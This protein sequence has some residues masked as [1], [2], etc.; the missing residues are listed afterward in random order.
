MLPLA[1]L[2]YAPLAGAGEG[3]LVGKYCVNVARFGTINNMEALPHMPNG[4]FFDVN[5]C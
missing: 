4:S 1:A 2:F 5:F 3:V